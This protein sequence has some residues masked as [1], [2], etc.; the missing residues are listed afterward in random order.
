MINLLKTDLYKLRKSSLFYGLVIFM[1]IM[2]VV[3]TA[4]N[5]SLDMQGKDALSSSIQ[6]TQMMV[7]IIPLTFG[8][9]IVKDFTTGY[10]KDSVAYG[11]SRTRIFLSNVIAFSIGLIIILLIFPVV[12]T[13][14]ITFLNGYGEVLTTDT[15][16]NILR[17]LFLMILVIVAIATLAALIAFATRSNAIVLLSILVVNF[18]VQAGSMATNKIIKDIYENMIF[19]QINLISLP[20]ISSSQITSV[21]VVS[22]LTIVAS[23]LVGVYLFEK[24]DIK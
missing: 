2:A 5:S 10:I 9:S 20:D 18:I 6:F 16:F 22:I 14:I 23:I 24:T 13:L 8:I 17:M 7:G 4:I 19:Y 15:I 21:V 11:Y 12:S 1:I 3:M